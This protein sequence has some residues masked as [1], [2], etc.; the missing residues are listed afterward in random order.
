MIFFGHPPT[1][2]SRAIEN[3]SLWKLWFRKSGTWSKTNSV[4]FYHTKVWSAN[5]CNK[6]CGHASFNTTKIANKF[7]KIANF[8]LSIIFKGWFNFLKLH[9]KHFQPT[10]NWLKKHF[11][12]ESGHKAYLN[13]TQSFPYWCAAFLSDRWMMSRNTSQSE[14]VVRMNKLVKSLTNVQSL[15]YVK[16]KIN[17]SSWYFM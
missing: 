16:L 4:I 14:T 8:M 17:E 6:I 2:T 5:N 12:F 7:T 13:C 9:S 3:M 11:R 15:I 1:S 10:I